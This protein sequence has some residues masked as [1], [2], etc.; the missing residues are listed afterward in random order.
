MAL[1]AGDAARRTGPTDPMFVLTRSDDHDLVKVGR[2]AN[3]AHQASELQTGQCFRVNVAAVFPGAGA[4]A[5]AVRAALQRYE[6]APGAGWLRCSVGEAL[7]TIADVVAEAGDDAGVGAVVEDGTE[8]SERDRSAAEGRDAWVAFAE[9]F[10]NKHVTPVT[11]MT[12]ATSAQEVL[13]TV[14][15]RAG[16]SPAFVADVMEECGWEET[17]WG[18]R[19]GVSFYRMRDDRNL[20]ARAR[21]R[22]P[23]RE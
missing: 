1:R 22:S 20:F 17:R 21:S 7:G 3:P 15:R 8:A 4:L 23:R 13:N 9:G 19:S 5:E 12:E 16:V 6:V 14:S 18:S 10:V 2:G 11:S